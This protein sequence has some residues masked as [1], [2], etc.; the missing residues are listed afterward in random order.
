[1]AAGWPSARLYRGAAWSA[2]VAGVWLT[3]AA[4]HAGTWQAVASAP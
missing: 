4:L 1:M 3:A 2:P